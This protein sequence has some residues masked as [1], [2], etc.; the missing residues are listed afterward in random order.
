MTSRITLL[1]FLALLL[2]YSSRAV[3]GNDGP[4]GSSG[5]KM[6]LVPFTVEASGDVVRLAVHN[7]SFDSVVL[8][9][10]CYVIP[11][12][13]GAQSLQSPGSPDL[14]SIAV[15]YQLPQK[16]NVSIEILSARFTDLYEVSV[17]PAVNAGMRDLP[18]ID[19]VTR[20]ATYSTDA[21]YPADLVSPDLPYISRNLRC[22]S[23]HFFPFQYNPVTRHLR[24]CTEMEIVIHSLPEPGV[25]ELSDADLRIQP[26]PEAVKR[27]VNAFTY[28]VL[29]SGQSQAG[30]AIMLVICPEEFRESIAPFTA[31]KNRCGINTVTRDAGEFSSAEQLA[32][33][34]KSFY[35]EHENLL[36]LLL[37]GDADQV[38]SHMLPYG[39][40]DNYYSYIAGQDHYPD[41]MVGRFSAVTAE[42][43][44]LQVRRS[45]EYEQNPAMDRDW[46]SSAVGIA[47]TMGPGDDGEYDYEHIRNMMGELKNSGYLSVSEFFDGSQGGYDQEGDPGSQSILQAVNKGTGLI[48]YAGHGSTNA[49]ATGQVSR[50]QLSTLSNTG[51]Y[52]LVISAACENGNFVDHACLAEAWLKASSDGKP[53]GAAGALMASG[54][55]TSYPPMEAQDAMIKMISTSMG[56]SAILSFGVIAVNGCNSMNNRYGESGFQLTDTWVLFG[57]PSLAI[58]TQMPRKIT[59]QHGKEFGA[60]RQSFRVETGIPSGIA[61]LT[62]HGELLGSATVE[63]GL[64]VLNLDKPL[65]PDSVVLTVIGA[66]CLPYETVIPVT[67]IPSVI[68]ECKPLNHSMRMPI[69]TS[70]SWEDGNGGLPEYFK[71]Y[72]GTDY[73]PTNLLNG[74]ETTVAAFTPS[75]PLAYHTKYYWR[76]DAVNQAGTATGKIFEFETIYG[77]DEDF[78]KVTITD[79]KWNSGWTSGWTIDTVTVFQGLQSCRSGIV[80]QGESSSLRYSCNVESC[81][82]S[83]FWFRL[84]PGNGDGLL[85]FIV[86]GVV[87]QEWRGTLDW[88]YAMFPIEAGFHELEWKYIQSGSPG[89]GAWID[90]VSL[91][92]H[93]TMLSGTTNE[94]RVCEGSPFI[95]D[96]WAGNFNTIAWESDGD[97]T[98]DDPTLLNPSYLPGPSDLEN[99]KVNLKMNVRGFDHC[100]LQQHAV[101]LHTERLP[102]ITLPSDTLAVPGQP[103]VLDATT[104]LAAMYQWQPSGISSPVLTLEEASGERGPVTLE[105]VVTSASGCSAQK[106][107]K[108]YFSEETEVPSFAVYPNPCK[109]S[110]TLE[111]EHG[112]ARLHEVCLMNS[113][114]QKVWNQEGVIEIISGQVFD[115]PT[116]P[117]GTYFLVTE[118]AAGRT[119]KSLVIR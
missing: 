14:P 71:V 5:T 32:A 9:N 70:F 94:G 83:G 90:D 18:G 92:V 110:F 43:V 96:A 7:Y 47:S 64:A 26:F 87:Q 108:V 99:G 85:Q 72:L 59:V 76:I 107:I 16:G 40:S 98:F 1:L 67:R 114:G 73:P 42:E 45:I 12:I 35:Y 82:F 6:A 89:E 105:L 48:L 24:I 61:S 34:V 41:I 44:A 2:V 101:T 17:P 50:N 8:D 74:L 56:S 118:H 78:E 31:W 33:F 52:P 57:D 27:P 68:A 15:E 109:E 23:L 97:G 113:N 37:V 21:F 53:A 58:R 63:N 28:P 95:A 79:T 77:P 65:E 36:Y 55:Q 102:L 119:V 60:G 117:S 106:L 69:S 10:A 93:A 81:D 111:P 39:A 54:S 80:S 46:F 29:K 86:D 75:V 13:E 4:T 30:T 51:Y 116:L 88:N 84:A 3:F 38:P 62:A 91:P 103:M 19:A 20:S 115:L 22:Q 25:N 112:P 49:W 100:S 66:D 11:R 104:G